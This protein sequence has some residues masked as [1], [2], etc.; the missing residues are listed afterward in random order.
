[1]LCLKSFQQRDERKNVQEGMEEAGMY[2]R[3]CIRP[4]YYNVACQ[5]RAR[6]KGEHKGRRSKRR[7]YM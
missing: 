4:V 3:K 1:M 7:P 6:Q 2:E 5:P